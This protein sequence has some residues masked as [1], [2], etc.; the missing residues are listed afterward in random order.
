MKR[1]IVKA[2]RADESAVVRDKSAPTK[3]AIMLLIPIIST[4]ECP[5]YFVNQYKY[6]KPVV[7]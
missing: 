1:D 3:I 5:R 4:Y 7:A 2:P 6:A